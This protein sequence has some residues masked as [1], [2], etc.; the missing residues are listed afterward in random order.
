MPPP[1]PAQAAPSSQNKF[2]VFNKFETMDTQNAR[3]DLSRDRAAWM[4]NLQPIGTSRLQVVP[5]PL[6]PS[7]S[8]LVGET[9]T[10]AF[11]ANYPHAIGG[12][13]LDHLIVFA[14]SGAAYEVHLTNGLVTQFATAGTF[15]ATPDATQWQSARVL[16]AD[17]VAGYCTWDGQAFVKPGGVSPVF[18]ITNG[19]SGY[20]TPTVTISG[21]SGAGATA[22]ATQVGGVITTVTLTNAGT[23][24]KAGD[25]I[26]VTINPVGGGAGA[27]VT[28]KI[29]PILSLTPTT[30]AVF[31]GRVWL[32]GGRVLF[33]TGTGGFDDSAAA[34]ASGQTTIADADLVHS[35]T[36]L[37]SL[38]NYLYIF[39]DQSIKQIGTITVSGSTTLFTVVTLSSDQ[40]TTFPQSIASYNR[41][42]MF[43][44]KVGVYAVFGASVEKISSEMDGIFQLIDF[45][46][47]L[48][49]ALND[50]SN[51]RCYLLLVRYIDPARN[52]T[53]SIIL[54]FM[55]KRWFVVS[56][57]DSLRAICSAP[58]SGTLQT[59]GSSGSDVTQLLQSTTST[60]SFLLITALSAN[61]QPYNQ[62]RAITIGVAQSSSVSGTLSATSDSENNSSPA[63]YSV[64]T[65]VIWIN[66]SAQQ[67]NFTNAG[68]SVVTFT[69]TGFVFSRFQPAASGICLGA[70][71]SGQFRSGYTVNAI[72]V[73]YSDGPD[74][75]SKGSV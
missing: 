16:I 31:Q 29:W 14:Q 34:N 7:L 24:Y 13:P 5:A 38:N 22:I 32:G 57:G 12:S 62:K 72:I 25:A 18:T 64:S 56:Q 11:Y 54:S 67:V 27:V 74:M 9:V 65:P 26:T 39:G 45:T 3:Y 46:Q 2:L 49:A 28:G 66:L 43:A 21:G 33:W 10:V 73:Q 63:Q 70:S 37:R 47:P 53:R 4:E 61:G 40:G 41:L 1:G 50:I 15:S 55:Q 52:V 58:I 48:Q 30:I 44:N 71:L 19:G 8:T 51:I 6:L 20:V 36:A 42:I 60:V 23:G 59:F 17:S 75:V 68:G 69:G 35:I